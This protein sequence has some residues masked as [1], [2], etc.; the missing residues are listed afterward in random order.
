M[1]TDVPKF[2]DLFCTRRQGAEERGHVHDCSRRC[3]A[4][5][6][7]SR[8]RRSSRTP[9]RAA[10]TRSSS[11]RRAA[12]RTS[13]SG[14]STARRRSAT[15]SRRSA[16]SSTR[17]SRT[18]RAHSRRATSSPARSA[19]AWSC[20]TRSTGWTRASSPRTRCTRSAATT[21]PSRSTTR[22]PTGTSG[23]RRRT[24]TGKDADKALS[25]A[26]VLRLGLGQEDEAVADVKQYQKDYGNS[27]AD[28]DGADR[29][30]D[31]RSLRR[32]GGL[33]QR[34]QGARRRDGHARQGAAGHPGPGARDARARAHAPQGA[35][36]RRSGEYE[37]VRKLWGD[38]SAAQAKIA[39]AYKTEGDDQRAHRLGKALD[40][41]GEAMF[42][43]A[44]EQQEGR[45]SMRSPFPV[46]KGPGT[47]DDIKKYM[48]KKVDALGP[49]EAARR[50]RR[51]TRSTR[52]SPSFSRCRRR[53]GSS[54]P[55]RAPA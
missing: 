12:R 20:S 16:R 1:I 28:R 18:R 32:Q 21:R 34:A 7:A 42:F 36:S 3:S 54:P 43:A 49:E 38:G 15:T 25:D 22:R 6:S 31:R 26:I 17:S 44:E 8:R 40:A 41:V 50:S 9:T 30:R 35:R 33:G 46:Y 4:T 45:R 11:S 27:N 47:K 5:S 10:T 39:D 29:V 23:T 37:Q 53:A 2:I 51:S 19:R 48:D 52:R 55:A 24:R 13:T 14:R